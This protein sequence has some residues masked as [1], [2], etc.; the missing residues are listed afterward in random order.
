[1]MRTLIKTATASLLAGALLLF[2]GCSSHTQVAGGSGA[3]NPG[4]TVS[5]AMSVQLATS[6][7]KIAAITGPADNDCDDSAPGNV[8]AVSSI[9]ASDQGGTSIILTDI[10][11]SGVTIHFMVDSTQSPAQLL[12]GMRSPPSDLS[13]DSN[14]I[15]LTPAGTFDALKAS[16]DS[17]ASSVTLPIARYTGVKLVFPQVNDSG[18]QLENDTTDN[19]I[20]MKG[21]FTYYGQVHPLNIR[22]AYPQGPY[23]QNYAFDGGVFT[24]STADTTHL[25][26]RFNANQWFTGINVSKSL[27]NGQYSFDNNGAL[28]ITNFSSRSPVAQA[29]ASV[30]ADFLASGKLTIY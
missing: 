24:L 23:K 13:S 27:G 12:S 10:L 18:S 7:A 14:S 15:I 2:A 20:L 4:G 25:E 3:G 6:A 8:D 17:S 28:N 19:Q 22:I 21:T 30:A 11:L 29:G 1:M 16:P 26:L 5:I 9:T